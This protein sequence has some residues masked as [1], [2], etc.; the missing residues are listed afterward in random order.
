VALAKLGFADVLLLDKSNYPRVKACGSGLSPLALAMLE[1]LDLTGRFKN[2]AVIRA[3]QA[4]GPGGTTTRI[5]AGGGAWVI[6]R[7]EFDHGLAQAAAEQG[8]SFRPNTKVV[9]LL[10]DPQGHI[11]GVRTSDQEIEA[12]LVVCADGG[13]SRFSIDPT[14]RTTILTIMGWWA[15]T[16]LP[17]DE[18]VMIWDRRLDGYY[19]WSFPEP[20]GLV[21]IGLTIPKAA[22]EARRLR[23]L[24]GEIL[25]EHFARDLKGAEQRGKWIG[26]PAVV[27]KRVGP[28]A[29]SRAL[30]VGEAARLV[31]PGTVEG[32]GFA[33]ESGIRAASFAAGHFDLGTGFSR[34]AL[35]KYRRATARAVVPKF[36]AGAAF[37]QLMRSSKALSLLRKV[38]TGRVQRAMGNVVA[39]LVGD[40]LGKSPGEGNIPKGD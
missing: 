29:E 28:I 30:W 7:S 17:S 6:P 14:P 33:L 2:H 8:A 35:E 19:A 32:I 3:L 25:D 10:R 9:G 15:G 23:G 40:D 16:R 13:A 1:R 36:W 20:G 37:V 39:K 4:K 24:F 26:L 22:P 27:T 38:M 11:R 21:N 12:D 18:A 31:M 5:Q 34:L